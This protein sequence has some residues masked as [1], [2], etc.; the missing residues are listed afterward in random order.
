M[1]IFLTGSEGFIGSHLV[2]KLLDNNH[3]VTAHYLYNFSN[4]IGWLKSINNKKLKKVN[5]VKGDI[6]DLQLTKKLSK[7]HNVFINLAALIGIP[8]SYD[9][10]K[11][12]Y[13]TNLT[14]TLNL[15]ECAKHHKIKQFI[16]TSTSEV[17]GSANYTPIDEKHPLNAQSPYAASKIA[18]DQLALS[19]YNSFNLPV[20]IIR[21]F[22]TFGPRQS[23]RA[24]IPTIISQM[25]GNK[26]NIK[27]GNIFPKRD[28]NFVGDV[29]DA[30][31]KTLYKKQSFGKVINVGSGYNISIK[32][33]IKLVAQAMNKK[34]YTI[35]IEKKRKRQKLSEV[36]NLLCDNNRAKKILKWKPRYSG[37]KGFSIALSNTINW[38]LKNENKKFFSNNNFIT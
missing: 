30:F 26:P 32:E 29:C 9:A 34:K 28:F 36:D 8:Y 38:Y 22:N 1:K 18:S 11:S 27:V 17:Y 19:Y 24:I 31:V 33:L 7:G 10:T 23:L 13:D 3:Q 4:S 2:E 25:N 15:L 6:R 21:P 16:Q 5:I 37:K 14:G 20:T 12:Y 35:K